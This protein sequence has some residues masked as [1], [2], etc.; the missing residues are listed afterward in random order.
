[1]SSHHGTVLDETPIETACVIVAFHRLAP[2]QRLLE[3]LADPRIEVVIVN[4]GDD[5][6]VRSLSPAQVVP[7]PGNPGYAAAVNLGVSRL[8]ADTVVFMNDDVDVSATDILRL[9]DRV[10]DGQVDV[11]VP[12]IED[13]EGQIE[14]TIAPLLSAGTLAWEWV[15]L[16]DRPLHR[17]RLIRGGERWRMPQR[18]E[19]I[20]AAWAVIVAAR[21][22]L[23]RAMPLPEDYFLYWEEFEWFYRLRSRGIVVEY[24]PSI[25]ARHQGGRAVVTPDKCAL[26]ARNAVRCVRRTRGRSAAMRMWLVVVLWNL[27]LLATSWI[28]RQGGDVLAARRAGLWAAAGAWR[29]LRA[30]PS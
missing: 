14:F 6:R 27:R 11:V 26:L 10:R 29:E 20:D 24:D 7:M 21:A 18:V 17:L 8:T 28:L 22:S 16:P 23:L 5:P 30:A 25:R 3:S 12:R 9:A 4:V 15:L 1:L 13:A 19:R 2:L